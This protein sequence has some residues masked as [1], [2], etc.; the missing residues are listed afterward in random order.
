M[1]MKIEGRKLAFNLDIHKHLVQELKIVFKKDGVYIIS[2][3]P[4][5]IA[6]AT[7]VLKNTACEEYNINETGELTIGIDLL[8]IRGFLKIGK[9][10]DI[11]IF[12]YDSEN[13]RL[14]VRLGNLVR[15]MGLLDIEG[16]PDLK[17][18]ELSWANKT[19]LGAK[20]L[21]TGIK[22]IMPENKRNRFMLRGYMTV[23]NENLIFENYSD[24]EKE[25]KTKSAVLTKDQ[26]IIYNLYRIPT[27]I[28]FNVADIEEQ[29]R[30]YKRFFDE[31]TIETNGN[32]DPIKISASNNDMTVE[33]HHVVI[34]ENDEET[35]KTEEKEPLPDLE[36]VPAAE[37]HIIVP[38][39]I[40]VPMDPI[41]PLITDPELIP[42]PQDIGSG[43][44]P[45]PVIKARIT[46]KPRKIHKDIGWLASPKD[47]LHLVGEIIAVTKT[48]YL[49]LFRG[50]KKFKEPV[51][52]D[53]E[54]VEVYRRGD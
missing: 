52:I 36:T 54:L 37:D 45:E 21:Y 14:V 12:D 9:P 32:S 34:I 49:I 15:T 20:V 11:F 30:E 47:D 46:K 51:E 16:M 42:E 5:H 31:V 50:S 18:L 24:D 29:V 6:I 48:G 23:T 1:H 17:P 33:Y 8:K 25:N 4:A 7:T 28:V 26:E 10:S 35:Q 13:H 43:P 41:E 19:V 2:F 22:A 39:E 27:S 3:D 40:P 53:R 44:V 38:Q